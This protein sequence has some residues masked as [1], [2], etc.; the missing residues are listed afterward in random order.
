MKTI[1]KIFYAIASVLLVSS[2][3]YA[4]ASYP[5]AIKTFTTKQNRVDV[6]DAAHINDLQNEVTAIETEL[7]TNPK[8]SATDVKT[9]LAVSLSAT[10]AIANAT[11]FPGSPITAQ[12]LFRTDSNTLFIYNGGTWYSASQLSNLIFQLPNQ[13]GMNSKSIRATNLTTTSGG[14]YGYYAETGGTYVTQYSTKFIKIAGVSTV[15]VYVVLWVS[16]GDGN[17]DSKSYCQVDIGGATGSVSSTEDSTTPTWYS[18]TINVSGLTNG[19][20]YDVAVQLKRGHI[21]SPALLGEGIG[22]GS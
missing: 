1:N 12:P 11:S 22:F 8:S 19:N 14:N 7:G 17:A 15:T 4:A 9:R 13:G 5:S 6:Y 2:L 3:V 21:N 18:F 16:V 20:T 10:G